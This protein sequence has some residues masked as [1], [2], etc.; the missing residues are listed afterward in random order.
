MDQAD[1][2]LSV[3]DL[4][5]RY[6]AVQALSGVSL[7][8]DEGEI[9]SLIGSNGAGKTTLMS[10]VMGL[11]SPAGGSVRFDGDDITGHPTES[12]VASGISLVPERRRLFAP[13]TVRENLQLGAAV[14]RRSGPQ[15]G[16]LEELLE[17]FPILAGRT[18]QPA[19]FLS[20]GE[21]QQL[22]IAR[23]LMSRPRLLLLDEPSLGLAPQLVS[24]VFE[25]I[26]T[27][28]DRGT[29]ILLVE[30]NAFQALDVAD[31]AYVLRIGRIEAERPA[32]ELLDERQLLESYLGKADGHLT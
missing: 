11:M 16:L 22:A 12:I 27:L 26:R 6:G 2:L 29:T 21:A 4:V 15:D 20:G 24:S 28:R 25:L 31:R 30:Q 14:H 19:G 18:N 13:L 17:M 3:E 23:A 9:V 5:V 10:T 1:T 32:R 7:R 8:V